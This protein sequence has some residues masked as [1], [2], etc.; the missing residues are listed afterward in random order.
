LEGGELV[1]AAYAMESIEMKL[2][3]EGKLTRAAAG[4]GWWFLEGEMEDI[5][6]FA[7]LVGRRSLESLYG[8]G[9]SSGRARAE[10][11]G[12]REK[13]QHWPLGR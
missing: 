1:A 8:V 7:C 10:Q 4:L 6:G 12:N 5:N 9:G 13:A 11:V 3:G 2:G